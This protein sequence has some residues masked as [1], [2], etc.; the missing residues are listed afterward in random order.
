[1]LF[2]KCLTPKK[3]L[4]QKFVWPPNC[5][6]QKCWWPPKMLS[7]IFSNCPFFGAFFI[8]LGQYQ[9]LLMILCLVWHNCLY[10]EWLSCPLP[11]AIDLVEQPGLGHLQLL[12]LIPA[13]LLCQ[14]K[15]VFFMTTDQDLLTTSCLG[16]MNTKLSSLMASL[17]DNLVMLKLTCY[18]VS[19]GKAK[20]PV[21]NGNSNWIQGN[22]FLSR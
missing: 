13:S 11:P 1:M 19:N 14:G 17:L 15:K 20:M 3:L 6:F 4:S 5:F 16:N 9:N 8:F 12:H 22:S 18:I 2:K 21:S 10:N 7:Q